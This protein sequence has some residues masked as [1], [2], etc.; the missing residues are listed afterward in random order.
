MR[1]ATDFVGQRYRN[2]YVVLPVVKYFLLENE[3]GP[4]RIRG[5]IICRPK[6]SAITAL[7]D[8]DVFPTLV[9]Q[10][11]SYRER[12]RDMSIKHE[13]EA[14]R[15]SRLLRNE[16]PDFGDDPPLPITV[17]SEIPTLE[18][19]HEIKQL[20]APVFNIVDRVHKR[21]DSEPQHVTTNPVR[22]QKAL[23]PAE[24]VEC[25]PVKF[26]TALCMKFG[27]QVIIVKAG[28]IVRHV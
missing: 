6:F 28:L 13:S 2:R 5:C 11:C 7:F 1:G 9:V 25:R 17:I 14:V 23:T 26:Y 16:A 4:T 19:G 20:V 18:V 27:S 15:R 3:C 21:T 22:N 8:L 10:E 24:L 12:K